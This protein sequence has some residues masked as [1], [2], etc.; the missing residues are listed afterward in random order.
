M[1]R[2]YDVSRTG[3]QSWLTRGESKRCARDRELLEAIERVFGE[4]D[5]LY[6]SPKVTQALRSEGFTVGENRVARLMRDN[7]LVARCARIYRRHAGVNRFFARIGNQIYDQQ[8]T[9]PDQI[10]VG[11]VTY[12]EVNG[13]WRYLAVVMDLYSRKIADTGREFVVGGLQARDDQT[14][15]AGGSVLPLR[16][17]RRIYCHEVSKVAGR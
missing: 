10:W 5:G 16:P 4:V 7:D 14:A 11:D 9:G 12:L 3:Y 1:L 13:V 6:G 17:R 8:A 2:L 15:G